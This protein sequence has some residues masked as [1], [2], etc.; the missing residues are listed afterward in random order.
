MKKQIL[1]FLFSLPIL[2]LTGGVSGNAEEIG[3]IV[4][5]EKVFHMDFD[6]AKLEGE[7]DLKKI[8]QEELGKPEEC[9]EALFL[10]KIKA[11]SIDV[12]IK[13][14]WL[15]LSLPELSHYEFSNT[16]PLLKNNIDN[17]TKP[18]IVIMQET[19]VR[20]GLLKNSDGSTVKQRGFFGPLTW[21]SLIRL[22]QIKGLNS[23]DENFY[24]HLRDKVNDLIKNMAKDPDYIV[25]HPLPDKSEM[26]PK[27]DDQL[28]KLWN[29]NEYLSEL[30]QQAKLVQPGAIPLDTTLDVNIEGYVNVERLSPK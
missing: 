26:E 16:V 24:Q 8:V 23:Q 28:Y 19:L 29:E 13:K 18:E 14:D 7:L 5:K 10:C 4:S 2:I 25:K 30:S 9:S 22:A 6:E 27:K 21:L 12:K 17:L 15:K 3:K 11:V 1:F 20:R